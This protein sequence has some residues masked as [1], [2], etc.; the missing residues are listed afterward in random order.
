MRAPGHSM[1]RRFLASALLLVMVIAAGALRPTSSQVPYALDNPHPQGTQAL[2]TLLRDEGV[3][4]RTLTSLR[5]VL[6]AAASGPATIAVLSVGQLAASERS[7]LAASGADLTVLGTLYQDLSGLRITSQ[8]E[9]QPVVVTDEEATSDQF[10][11][12]DVSAGSTGPQTWLQSSGA[13]TSQILTARCTDPDAQAAGSLQGTTGSLAPTTQPS[14]AVGCFP[15]PGA[16]PTYAYLS[17]RLSGGGRLRVIADADL[18]TNA[19]LAQEGHAALA[20]RSLGHQPELIWFD[21]AHASA[22]DG[23]WHP[24]TLPPWLI[25]LMALG[26][27]TALTGALVRGRR[28]GR[29]VSED[30]PVVVEPTLT[31]TGRAQ[32]YRHAHAR[33]E[34]AHALRAGT[35]TRLGRHLGVPQPGSRSELVAAIQAASSRPGAQIDHLIYGPPPADDQAL[36]RLAHDLHTLE[37]EILPDEQPHPAHR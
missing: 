22:L 4:V 18:V 36:V 19:H 32:L 5:Q 31:T 13:S 7:Q 14:D 17:A 28:F 24:P 2:G 8:E 15:L 30:L 33:R 10:P 26:V 21:A 37:S 25:P 23:I 1:R 12:D 9:P 3:H 27:T 6:D 11:E 16:Q 34:A 29:L 35:G 20:I